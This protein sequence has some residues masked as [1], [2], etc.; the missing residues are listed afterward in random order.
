MKQPKTTGKTWSGNFREWIGCSI[1]F[2]LLLSPAFSQDKEADG[3]D[4]AKTEAMTKQIRDPFWPVGFYPEGWGRSAVEKK[5]KADPVEQQRQT[6]V[7]KGW[8]V[9]RKNIV[10]NGISSTD[11]NEFVAIIN[12]HLKSVGEMIVVDTGNGKYFWRVAAVQ[13]PGSV[14]LLRVKAEALGSVSVNVKDEVTK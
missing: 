4:T 11:D 3:T 1:C 2:V 9:A 12:N 13:P 5:K 14:K 10:I 8:D 7:S 6:I